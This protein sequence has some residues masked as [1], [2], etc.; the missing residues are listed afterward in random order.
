MWQASATGETADRAMDRWAGQ[1]GRSQVC[2]HAEQATKPEFFKGPLLLPEQLLEREG[3]RDV[4]TSAKQTW[5]K[6][7]LP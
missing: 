6:Q 5:R 1:A 3:R 7:T 4:H 2:A